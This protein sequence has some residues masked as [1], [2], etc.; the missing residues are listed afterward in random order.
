MT[1]SYSN[2]TRHKLYFDLNVNPSS[3]EQPIVLTN[4]CYEDVLLDITI[5]LSA[6]EAFFIL[7]NI[8]ANAKSQGVLNLSSLSFQEQIHRSIHPTNSFHT[9]IIPLFVIDYLL[10]LQN[11]F[12]NNNI[13]PEY[14]L[15]TSGARLLLF[16]SEDESVK[17][18]INLVIK[19]LLSPNE[20][21]N[22]KKIT[23]YTLLTLLLYRKYPSGL[24]KESLESVIKG[25]DQLESEL[26]TPFPKKSNEM[27]PVICEEECQKTFMPIF[28]FQEQPIEI[29][30]VNNE[31]LY[32]S[33]QAGCHD[34]GSS[35]RAFLLLAKLFNHT[36][37][38][39]ELPDELKPFFTQE[40]TFKLKLVPL[41]EDLLGW[42][43][44]YGFSVYMDLALE[45][46]PENN[47]LVK[48]KD[49]AYRDKRMN[50]EMT[51]SA[52]ETFILLANICTSK[53]I[54]TF[55]TT[56][57]ASFH[58]WDFE[59]LIKD[60]IVNNW[61][62]FHKVY[63]RQR[64]KKDYTAKQTVGDIESRYLEEFWIPKFS[65][66]YLKFLREELLKGNI[67]PLEILRLSGA[68]VLML[69]VVNFDPVKN[70]IKTIL[71]ELKKPN[72][73]SKNRKLMY[74][75]LLE[76]CRDKLQFFNSGAEILKIIDDFY[77]E[78]YA[79]LHSI[80]NIS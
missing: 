68:G 19:E 23:T 10:F 64:R 45:I 11:S 80:E 39:K 49:F 20:L 34:N 61:S 63:V 3:K 14:I 71:M 46:N 48:L 35:N 67:T 33:P 65:L 25:L 30:M 37:T 58:N 32:Y 29:Y 17:S 38:S 59:K 55:G 77:K 57:G 5:E 44:P 16:L 60:D 15:R 53:L 54:D 28:W 22:T 69:L 4:F 56:L 36:N 1:N 43:D 2:K 8:C 13:T 76:I 24:L 18:F 72:K 26:S 70:F 74:Y 40:K 9:E 50:L 12:K 66:T 52:K 51:L 31:L 73:L 78:N 41:Y 6:K 62:T 27:E 21:N 47:D 75:T 42:N 79:I 7:A